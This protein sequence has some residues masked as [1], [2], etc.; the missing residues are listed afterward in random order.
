MFFPVGSCYRPGS[1]EREPVRPQERD[2]LA[3]SQQLEA[4]QAKLARNGRMIELTLLMVS[5]LGAVVLALVL[6]LLLG[7]A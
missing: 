4:V 6:Y 1:P 3:K 2:E 5:L 7:R